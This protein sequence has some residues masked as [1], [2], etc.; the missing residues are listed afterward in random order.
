VPGLAGEGVAEWLDGGV[1]D[2]RNV[3][4]LRVLLVLSIEIYRDCL[5][6]ETHGKTGIIGPG[7]V[8]VQ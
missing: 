8:I 3:A 2:I 7:F 5:G 6:P 4:A 1:G